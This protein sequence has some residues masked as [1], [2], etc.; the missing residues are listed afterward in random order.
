[1]THPPDPRPS[2]HIR[3]FLAVL[4]TGAVPLIAQ[5]LGLRFMPAP[6][7]LAAINPP[8]LVFA[9]VLAFI[10]ARALMRY[11]IK[12]A[13]ASRAAW[14]KRLVVIP[15]AGLVFV[16]AYLSV[17]VTLPMAYTALAGHDSDLRVIAGKQT[18][19]PR[20]ICRRP[21]NLTYPHFIFNTLCDVPGDIRETVAR[22]DVLILEG[23]GNAAG[24]FYRRVSKAE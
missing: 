20:K 19:G 23:S 8:V 12:H 13:P 15:V 5:L 9:T 4:L 7:Y 16:T 14:R 6:G 11:E 3:L 21:V 22:G 2:P 17:A 1:M 24:I 10:N 18:F